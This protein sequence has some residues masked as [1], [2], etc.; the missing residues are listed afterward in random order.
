MILSKSKIDKID[1][2][3]VI[4][5]R[6]QSECLSE[7]LFIVPTNRKSRYLLRELISLSPNKSTERLNIE[8]I[9][10]YST[11]LLSIS[12]GLTE[13]VEEQTAIVLLNQAFKKVNLKYFSQ[14][15]D[16]IPFGTLERVKNVISEY[17]RHGISP[18]RLR[19]EADMLAGSEQIKAEDI[20]DI[21]EKYQELL[22]DLQLKEIGDIYSSLNNLPAEEIQKS[23]RRIYPEVDLVYIYGFDEF[24]SPEIEII[25][26]TSEIT[27]VELYVS[28]DYY[29]YNNSIFSHLDQCHD[30]L[31]KKG[32]SEITDMS[33]SAQTKFLQKVRND[34]FKSKTISKENYLKDSLIKITASS[35]EE[36]VELI[37]KEIKEIITNKKAEPSDIC[38]VFNLISNYSPVVRDRFTLFGI[39]F[40][41]T[42]R[43]ALSTS[44]PVIALINFLEIADNDF[45][46]KNI[47]RALNSYFINIEGIDLSNLLKVSVKLKIISGLNNWNNS[48][49]DAIMELKFN[50]EDEDADWLDSFRKALS[51]I[52]RI[53]TWMEPFNKKMKAGEFYNNII[54]MIANLN[55]L[56]K[57]L[58]G[59]DDIVEKD[60]KAFTTFIK[61]LKE[62]TDLFILEFGADEKFPLRFF[63]NQL[64]TSAS[65]TRYNIQE[66]P[67][68]GV[69]ITNLN[70]IRGLQFSY[71]F[72]AGLNDGDLPTRYQPEIFFSGSFAVEEER[73]QIEERY[74][75]YQSLCS[76]KKGLYLTHPLFDDRKELVESS[77]LTEITN[78]FEVK[79]KGREDYSGTIYSKPELLRYI[80]EQMSIDKDRLNLPENADVNLDEIQNAI[81]INKK[82]ITEPFGESAYTGILENELSEQLK[83]RLQ[84]LK[85]EQF[86]V[87]QLETY[88]KCP[89]KYFAERILNLATIEE[90][91]EELEAFELGSLL[92][93]ILYEFY[94]KLK[95]EKIILQECSE[96][97][98]SKADKILFDIAEEKFQELHLVSVLSFF[99]KEKILGINNDRKNSIL[100]KF[101]EYERSSDDGFIPE[102]FEMTFGK[103]RGEKNKERISAEFKAGKVKVRGK[104]DRIEIDDEKNL[105]KVVDYKSGGKKPTLIDLREGLSL[106]LPLYLFAATELIN[107]QLDKDYQPAGMEIY[108]LKYSEKDFGKKAVGLSGRGKS[109]NDNS[110]ETADQLIKICIEAINKYVDLISRGIFHL[111]KLEDRESKV[112]RY[113]NFRSI[114]RITEVE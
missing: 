106:Q 22:Q 89:Y 4:N 40:N 13:P 57:I 109:G 48:L 15:K 18:G 96:K 44:P 87:T 101:L 74:H 38:V 33:A 37:A 99:E 62:L 75:F 81:E 30:G 17:K 98:F 107:A 60:L 21:Y 67:G 111:S 78:L 64:K 95:K 5:E 92:H 72:I 56:K 9:G 1:L 91:T 43:F 26:S 112:C 104:I 113:C 25:H 85:E 46:Y 84:S 110:I 105:L 7:V 16:G 80:G 34:L 77:F 59:N 114:C 90:P 68:Y 31:V 52:S 10:S 71:L 50:N 65:F 88:A 86:S 6:I 103:I 66:K 94:T 108:S 100:Y 76:W 54:T 8:T 70:E 3:A 61:N 32:F 28:L 73:H 47:F 42:D 41:L 11:G 82:R 36:E 49:N 14:Y 20:A 55:I 24:T 35:R 27:G 2:D 29:K 102:Y 39:P 93:K 63:I 83:E 23:F 19:K 45:Y 12:S 51:D 79:Q 97:D 69:Q 53:E 58:N